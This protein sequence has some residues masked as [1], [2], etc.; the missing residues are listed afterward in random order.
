M[1]EI[2]TG[3]GFRHVLEPAMFTVQ[4]HQCIHCRDESMLVELPQYLH[5]IE[6][7]D[8]SAETEQPDEFEVNVDWRAH[9]GWLR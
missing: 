9:P 6:E 2:S 7:R 1:L 8:L 4:I 3:V 5:P